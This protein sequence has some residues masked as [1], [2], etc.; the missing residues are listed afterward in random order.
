MMGDSLL[1][2]KGLM[3]GLVFGV[4]IGV[5]GALTIKRTMTYGIGAGLC[6]GFGCAIADML[7]AC[8]TVFGIQ[9]ISDW[10]LRY[11]AYLQFLGGVL[12][13]WIGIRLVVKRQEYVEDEVQKPHRLSFFCS[14]FLIAAMNPTTILTFIIAFSIFNIQGVPHLR[15]GLAVISGM[16]V[17][18]CSWWL[19]LIGLVSGLKRRLSETVLRY[20]DWGLAGCIILFGCM[21]IIGGRR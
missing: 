17:G 11:Q 16:L 19:M 8:M 20:I 13:V 4:P 3:I 14:S 2:V 10:M 9:F 12:V 18:T 1:F 5:I 15:G 6:S 21:V 7:Y